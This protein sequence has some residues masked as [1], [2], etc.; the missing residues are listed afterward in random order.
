MLAALLDWPQA[1][2]AHTLELGDGSAKVSR[3]IDGGLQTVEVK[4]PAVMT[5]DLRLNEPRYASLPNIMKAKKKPIEEKT[6]A[7]LGVDVT[8]RFKVLKV[9]RAAQAWRRRQSRHGGRTAGQAQSGRGAV[10]ASLVLAEHDN[11]AL[12]D[13]THKTVSA[14]A[15]ISTPVHVLV[16]GENCGAVADAAAKIAGVEK[17]LLADA[18][19][20]C[21]ATGRA[22]GGTDLVAGRTTMTRSWRP[23]PPPARTSCRA[24]PPSWIR[25]RFPK[26]S[27]VV[28]P[29]TFER[30]IYAGNAIETVQAPAGKKIITVRTTA[31]KAAEESGSAAIEKIAAAADPGTLQIRRRSLV[32]VGT[33]RT[34]LGQD[35][36]LGRTRPG[37]AENFKLLDSIADKLH[38]AVGASRAR[39][40]MRV[41]SPNDYQVG[42]T[43]KV[44]CARSLHRGG[45]FRRDPA[46]GGHE[47]FPGASWPSTRTKRRRFSRSPITGWWRDLFKALP[48]MD[49]ELEQARSSVVRRR[50]TWQ[51]RKSALSVP[52]RWAP[53]LR[54]CWR[55]PAMTW[56]W[57]TSTRMPCPRRSSAI[58]KNMQRQ[59]AKGLIKEDQIKP[60]LARIRVTQT[61]D[62]LQRPR[63][64]D[65]GGDRGRG[66]QEEDLP[67][68]LYAHFRQGA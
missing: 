28:S 37:S 31:F 20:L 43:G 10:M 32:Q 3:E 46:S 60:A 5:T 35:R 62:D 17:I 39:R 19:H 27:K 68:S 40:W 49:E 29:D 25:R 15:Q 2:F 51:L 26:S 12:K 11:T 52:A 7:D 23:P 53:A 42:Q 21:Q 1:T 54:M 48:E 24:S 61:L 38:A 16:A 65:R 44:G 56:C 18:R 34:D 45:H 8:P 4:L 55:W 9:S 14:A 13:A 41:M 66:D 6:P 57:T 67:G 22:D 50:A 63:P 58:E 30:P 64:G 59:A 36:D 33:S 47:G